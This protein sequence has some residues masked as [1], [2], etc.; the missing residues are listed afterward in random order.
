MF[1]VLQTSLQGHVAVSLLLELGET[2][3]GYTGVGAAYS[4]PSSFPVAISASAGILHVACCTQDFQ[5][6]Q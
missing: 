4:S 1:Y 5:L 6:Q 3:E 2:P